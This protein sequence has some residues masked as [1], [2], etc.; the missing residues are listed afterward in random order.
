RRPAS[1]RVRQRARQ[2]ERDANRAYLFP[3]RPRTPRIV[4]RG[5]IAVDHEQSGVFEVLSREREEDGERLLAGRR[6]LELRLGG[7]RGERAPAPLGTPVRRNGVP[8]RS[9]R[10]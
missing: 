3:G 5:E 2:V 9:S 10:P 6:R 7:G 8:E 4:P 1:F